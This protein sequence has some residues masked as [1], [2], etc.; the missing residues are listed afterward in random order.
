MSLAA[1]RPVV[2]PAPCRNSNVSHAESAV[3]L[4]LE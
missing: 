2:A 4:V 3:D 1:F